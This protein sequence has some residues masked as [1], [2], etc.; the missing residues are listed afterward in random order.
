MQ[1]VLT[2][3]WGQ[4]NRLPKPRSFCYAARTGSVS[5]AAEL[6]MLS[7][8]SVSLQIQALEKELRTA[9]PPPDTRWSACAS[10]WAPG[11]RRR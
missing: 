1:G 6:A 11:W 9:R 10:R 3:W 4:R 2:S 8:P 7:Q 5:R